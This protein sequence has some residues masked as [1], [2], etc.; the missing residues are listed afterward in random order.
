MVPVEA[1]NLNCNFNNT[2]CFWRQDRLRASSDWVFNSEALHGITDT[3]KYFSAFDSSFK[4]GPQNSGI[5]GSI[6][7]IYL[8]SLRKLKANESAI[9]VSPQIET[10]ISSTFCFE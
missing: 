6:Y 10:K 9:L 4:T 8:N 1:L 7:Y 2:L 5:N 3:Q